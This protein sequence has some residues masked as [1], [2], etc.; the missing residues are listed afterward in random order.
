[1]SDRTIERGPVE[2]AVSSS[3][4][5]EPFRKWWGHPP[6]MTLLSYSTSEKLVGLLDSRFCDM[7]L[8]QWGISES[9]ADGR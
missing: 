3:E 9:G 6:F 1:M 4:K 2:G 5:T 7:P 8:G